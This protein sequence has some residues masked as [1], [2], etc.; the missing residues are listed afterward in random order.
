MRE[1]NFLPFISE[2]TIL[3][4]QVCSQ[5]S[6]KPQKPCSVQADSLKFKPCVTNEHLQYLPF[7]Y[8]R[9]IMHLDDFGQGILVRRF[10]RHLIRLVEKRAKDALYV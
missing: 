1:I 10:V 5:V 2:V 7:L 4:K 9:R 3:N 8:Y 6:S